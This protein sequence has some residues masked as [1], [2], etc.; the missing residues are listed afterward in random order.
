[1]ASMNARDGYEYDPETYGGEGA[2]LLGRSQAMKSGRSM[3]GRSTPER[4]RNAWTGIDSV[5]VMFFK[6]NCCSS[7][8][9]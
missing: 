9:V 2:G 8:E 7:G 4:S 1:M 6:C 5:L 3:K